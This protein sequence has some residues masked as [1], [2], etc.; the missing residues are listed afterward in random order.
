[1]SKGQQGGR[2][3]DAAQQ[4]EDDI[5]GEVLQR[6]AQKPDP[7]LREIMLSLIATCT[8]SSRK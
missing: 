3:A 5:T 4:T 8:I 6:F 7:R 2:D 1:M